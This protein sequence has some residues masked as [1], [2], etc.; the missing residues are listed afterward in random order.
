[1]SED[2]AGESKTENFEK[3]NEEDS[4]LVPLLSSK[5][6]VLNETRCIKKKNENWLWYT[7]IVRKYYSID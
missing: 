7:S 1:M 6:F 4:T 2:N 3:K 5:Q